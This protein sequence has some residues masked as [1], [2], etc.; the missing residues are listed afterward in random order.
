MD[1]SQADFD[2][3]KQ[4]FIQTIPA[5]DAF[6]AQL[7]QLNKD[8]KARL[9]IMHQFM[10]QNDIMTTDLGGIT[11]EREEKTTVKVSLKTLEEVIENPADLEQYKRD[12]TVSREALRVRKPKRRRADT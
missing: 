1:L 7:K 2:E 8:Q 11:L 6:K 12:H 3:A 5:Q 10:Q 4:A 9:R